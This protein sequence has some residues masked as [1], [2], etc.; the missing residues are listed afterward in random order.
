MIFKDKLHTTTDRLSMMMVAIPSATVVQAVAAGGADCV[1]L[2]LEHGAIDY[3]ALHAM[4]AATAGTDCA[5]LVR[6]T[7][8]DD[9]HVK[10]A[11]DLGAEGL[12]FP[13]IRTAED[14]AWAV[15]SM[16]YPPNGHRSFGPFMAAAR[17]GQDMA[18][19]AADFAKRGVCILLAET[20]EAAENIEAIC[21]V[22]GI[23]AIIPAPYDLST[24][25]GIPGQFDHPDFLALI[26]KMEAAVLKAGLPMG[27]IAMDPDR[28]DAAFAKGNRIIAGVDVLMLR[29]LAT[30]MQGWCRD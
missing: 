3:G 12:V 6:I 22:P 30:Q 13:L 9:A 8:L 5:P 21:A 29:T 4:I 10:R 28:A 25:L 14:A 23:D 26:G 24:A 11:L 15:S 18:G 7:K 20:L 19:Y 1:M 16:H 17:Y 2:D 27:T